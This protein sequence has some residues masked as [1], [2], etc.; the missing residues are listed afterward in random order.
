MAD[1]NA[2]TFLDITWL[3]TN[4]AKSAENFEFILSFI[5]MLKDCP[6]IAIK[7]WITYHVLANIHP[8]KSLYPDKERVLY[9]IETKSWE[10]LKKYSLECV[11]SNS[12]NLSSAIKNI[13]TYTFPMFD[14]ILIN[15]IPKW[16]NTNTNHPKCNERWIFLLHRGSYDLLNDY[17]FTYSK[18]Y[19]DK[20]VFLRN[21]SHN[22]RHY[23]LI[24]IPPKEK[25]YLE[26]QTDRYISTLSQNN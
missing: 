25:A 19:V 22:K 21:I 2:P 26:E 1:T 8:D 6:C 18:R 12:S 10:D 4:N 16:N 7:E 20:F 9:Y 17:F 14:S 15:V 3:K 5:D 11:I 23:N 24:E 13:V